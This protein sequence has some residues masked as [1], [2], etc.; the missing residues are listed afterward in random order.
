MKNTFP[1]ILL[2]LIVLGC[3]NQ[4]YNRSDSRS[5]EP[6]GPKLKLLAMN[7]VIEYGFLTVQ[8]QVANTTNERLEHIQAVVS[9]F[10]SDGNFISSDSAL[11]EYDPLMPG[12]T[13]P[14]RV[15]TRHNPAMKSYRIEFKY[16]LGGAIGYEDARP[17]P[18]SKKNKK[19]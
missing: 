4:P 18:K 8:G 19:K 3:A 11:I 10:D 12:Q 9:H 15:G 13:S 6:S 16:I 1:L 5:V 7:G 2:L 14:F 17:E